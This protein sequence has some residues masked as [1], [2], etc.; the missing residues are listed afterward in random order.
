[1]SPPWTWQVWGLDW[2]TVGWI[3][4]IVFFFVWET[5][6]LLA[7][8]NQELTEHLRPVFLSSSLTW[9]IVLGVWLWLGW[10]FLLEAGNPIK[11]LTP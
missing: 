9:F 10:H 1:M 6:A 2:W 3:V 8:N 4:W 7:G 11:V 5:W